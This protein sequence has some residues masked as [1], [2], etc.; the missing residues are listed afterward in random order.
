MNKQDRRLHALTVCLSDSAQSLNLQ[1]AFISLTRKNTSLAHHV[2]DHIVS[3]E[4]LMRCFRGETEISFEVP[5][6]D[7]I[8]TYIS[9]ENWYTAQLVYS[10]G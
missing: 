6:S 2:E 7:L 3:K 4:E 5:L 1:K 8:L 9:S 10:A